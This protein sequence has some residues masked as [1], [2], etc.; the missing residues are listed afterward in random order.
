MPRLK[1]M[2]VPALTLALAAIVLA[3][4]ASTTGKTSPCVCDWTPV[5]AAELAVV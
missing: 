1:L 3:G 4:C 2:L 5:R